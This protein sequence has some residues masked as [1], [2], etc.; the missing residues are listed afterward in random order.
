MIG[1]SPDA[2]AVLTDLA[3]AAVA[4]QTDLDARAEAAAQ[5]WDQT[6]IPPW[7]GAYAGVR[8]AVETGVGVVPRS[9]AG[10]PSRLLLLGDSGT[11]AVIAFA[12]TLR[13]PERSQPDA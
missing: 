1:A 11:P 5:Q 12:F 4:A 2:V 6:G 8:A 9:R 7:A 10:T 13:P 3:R